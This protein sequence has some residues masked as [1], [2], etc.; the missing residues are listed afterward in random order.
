[1]FVF[2]LVLVSVFV[3]FVCEVS[4]LIIYVGCLDVLRFRL[5]VACCR[6]GVGT[7]W[8]RLFL[9]CASFGGCDLVCCC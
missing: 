6:G 8:R 9:W 7:V 3:G 4:W 2:F 1:V 5:W